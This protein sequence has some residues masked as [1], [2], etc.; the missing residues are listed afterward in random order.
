MYR[1]WRA[2]TVVAVVLLPLVAAPPCDAQQAPIT[3]SRRQIEA[4]TNVGSS[5]GLARVT[6]AGVERIPATA[7]SVT[8]RPGQILVAEVGRR[9]TLDSSTAGRPHFDLPARIVA[10]TSTGSVTQFS[11]A[12][13]PQRLDY[14]PGE[15]AFIG[16]V[17]V[18]LNDSIN[19]ATA[20]VLAA[21]IRIAVT[22]ADADVTPGDLELGHTNLP[23]AEVKLR[24]RA[25]SRDT[26][27]VHFRPSFNPAGYDVYLPVTRPAV[28]LTASPATIAGFGLE[29]T[30]LTVELPFS[31][32]EGS[33]SVVL[34]AGRS[35]PLDGQL[36]LTAGEPKSTRMPSQ[37]VGIDTAWATSAQLTPGF[38]VVRYAFPALFLA[39][40][41]LGGVAGSVA[42]GGVARSK[43]ARVS[44]GHLARGAAVGVVVGLIVAVLYA[45]GVNVLPVDLPS[46]FGEAVTF[47]AAAL[48]AYVGIRLPSD[49]AGRAA[50][51]A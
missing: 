26:V 16:A 9:P 21:P 20:V 12:V 8:V 6:A 42:R 28:A 39:A 17:R 46:Q 50:K 40:V 7:D 38:V 48:G 41:A 2:M 44:L 3:L 19:P 23:F 27:R 35:D 18:G 14:N 45:V 11:I 49:P 25:E 32:G 22:S 33:R 31:A 37:G 30:R 24:A 43:R 29:K 13:E 5:Q 36:T 51:R 47:A 4:R 15:R 10:P 34:R 1:A